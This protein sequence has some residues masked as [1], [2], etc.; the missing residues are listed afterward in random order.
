MGNGGIKMTRK[1]SKVMGA[2]L[3]VI[4][5]VNATGAWASQ[6]E[7]ARSLAQALMYYSNALAITVRGDKKMAADQ[8]AKAR[9]YAKKA[10]DGTTGDVRWMADEVY[11]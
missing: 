7:A 3:L 1:L 4:L 5:L 2:G 9:K 10:R 11:E 8:F 6:E